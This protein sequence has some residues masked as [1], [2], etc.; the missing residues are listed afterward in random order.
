VTPFAV[1]TA[2]PADLEAVAHVYTLARP[3]N[4]ATAE[5]LRAGD[6]SMDAAQAVHAR[7]LAEL[8]GQVIGAAEIMEPL[9]S[10]SVGHFWM[11]LVVLPQARGQGVGAAL[12]QALLAGLAAHQP[13][14]L[15]AVASEANLQALAFAARRG[16]HEIERFWDR[17]LAL[18]T[19]DAAQHTRPLPHGTR[20]VTLAE[21]M[22]QV[23]DV[24]AALH[25]LYEQARADLPRAPGELY[26]PLPISVAAA[27]LAELEP[28]SVVLAVHGG[29]PVGF[30]ALEPSGVPGEQMIAMTGVAHAHRGQGLARALKI[31]AMLQAR[32]QGWQVIRTSNHS[33]NA[34]MLAVND[35]LGFG[36]EP[37]RL[38][39]L[40][41]W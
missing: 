17:T 6:A 12:Y 27:F 30:T 14:Q 23:P 10:R 5:T 11:E 3:G 8:G 7:W 15:K 13:Q 25:P 33:S 38:G 18:D 32:A 20:L 40:R 31:A 16:H 35:A 4:P 24:V 21:Y 1:R 22:A 26:H 41:T 19:F 9:G 39:L 28:T 34:A 29:Q 37:A 36:R 2:T